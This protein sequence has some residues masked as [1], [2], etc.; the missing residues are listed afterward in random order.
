MIPPRRTHF[1]NSK[2][3]R[4]SNPAALRSAFTLIEVLV[5]M[6]LMAIVLPVAMRGMSIAVATASN[7]KH[8]AA[9]VSL[10]QAKLNEIV[11][12][13]SAQDTSQENGSG[14]FSPD[15]PAYQ[16][17]CQSQNDPNLG[18]TELTMTVSWSERGRQKD[19]ELSTLIMEQQ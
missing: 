8:K 5:T 2:F 14:D 12:E 16:W 9:A 13:V 10:A 7:A 1:R 18:L 15:F 17:T 3:V 11:Q 19:F 6:V 4:I